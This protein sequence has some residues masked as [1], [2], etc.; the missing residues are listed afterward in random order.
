ML[1][2]ELWLEHTDAI[3]TKVT[4][5][6]Y[7]V[8]CWQAPPTWITGHRRDLNQQRAEQKQTKSALFPESSESKV[9][10]RTCGQ[11]GLLLDPKVREIDPSKT[12]VSKV[13]DLAV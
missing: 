3:S 4:I 13:I 12:S 9:W 6:R 1:K 10:V 11:R 5:A 7:H 2:V 8:R